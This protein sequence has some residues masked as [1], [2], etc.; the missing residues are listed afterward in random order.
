MSTLTRPIPGQYLPY[1]DTYIR[2]VPVGADPLE[3]LT[4]LPT[5]LIGHFTDAQARYAYAPGKWSTKEM[6]GH[7]IDTERIFSYRALRFSR[8]DQTDLPGYEQDDYVPE[9]GANDRPLSDMLAEYATVRAA[10]L[11]LFRSFTPTQLDRTGTANNGPSGV[12]ALL[13]VIPGHEL[14]HIAVLRERYLP[15]LF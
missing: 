13:Y 2:H 7:I 8:N 11:S 5:Q 10:T 3:L 9:S 12:R 15:Q 6:L 4:Q 14:H 1:Y